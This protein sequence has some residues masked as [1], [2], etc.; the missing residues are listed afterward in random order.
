MLRLGVHLLHQPGSLDDIGETRVILDIGGDRQLAARLQPGHQD[1]LQVRARGVNRGGITRRPRADDQHFTVMVFRH[2]A[3]LVVWTA[4]YTIFP[5]SGTAALRGLPLVR[6]CGPP[7]YVVRDS[8]ILTIRY[9]KRR[10]RHRCRE[11]ALGW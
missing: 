3:N 7:R 5:Y 11:E 6:G 10:T 1:R 9:N 8:R 4:Y 2:P